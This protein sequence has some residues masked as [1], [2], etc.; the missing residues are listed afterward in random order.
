M[1]SYQKRTTRQIL[2]ENQQRTPPQQLRNAGV[3]LHN[4]RSMYNVG[5]AFRNCDAF[6]CGQLY[7]SGYTPRPPR[8][9]ISKTALG[10]EET[11]PWLYIEDPVAYLKQAKQNG[12]RLIGIEQTHESESLTA[13]RVE[14]DDKT[15]FFFGN[16]VTGLDE[17][18]LP[19]IDQ[20]LEIPQFGFKHSL[21]VS[22]SVG[23]VLYH[24][25]LTSE[26]K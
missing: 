21:N 9:E 4:I 2:A 13:F 20:C 25:L 22:V 17:D 11:V 24:I 12:V 16:E 7:L 14:S 15:I 18:L 5:A 23:T 19:L 1:R 6:G 26:K 3:W 8:P 10:A